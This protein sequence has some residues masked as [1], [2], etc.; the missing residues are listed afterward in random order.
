MPKSFEYNAKVVSLEMLGTHLM[1]MRI[2]PDA[3]M[4]PFV[5]GQ[6]ATLGLKQSSQ[7][8]D[9]ALEEKEPNPD[10]EHLIR[11]AYSVASAEDDNA[12]EFYLAMVDDGTL[13]PRLFA[14]KEGDPIYVSPKIV[15]RFTLQDVQPYKHLL[16]LSTG[17]GLAPYMSMLRSS[18]SWARGRKVIIMH[19]VRH[20]ADLGYRSEL[21]DLERKEQNFHYIPVLSSGGD[22]WQGGRGYI[23]DVLLD[24][25]T[26]KV[27]QLD[28]SPETCEAFL[29]GNPLMIE[30]AIERLQA[31]GFVLIKGRASGNIHI[32]EYW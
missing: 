22:D 9:Y 24:S 10:P 23:Q 6:Y 18:L 31:K 25:D 27:C 13:T 2:K 19:G 26:Q 15:G 14:L 17:T 28:I 8:A 21:E 7:R 4:K 5:S 32:E 29:C 3:P 12:L 16:L 30:G 1:V 20:E 11:R